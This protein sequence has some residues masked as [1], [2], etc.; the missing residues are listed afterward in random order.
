M[1]KFPNGLLRS[2]V[3]TTS[4]HKTLYAPEVKRAVNSPFAATPSSSPDVTNL[5]VGWA[6]VG[7]PKLVSEPQVPA[8]APS[9]SIEALDP[10]FW[11]VIETASHKHTTT[12]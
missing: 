10:L 7:T 1:A 8:G 4:M 5:A 12:K 9:I 2:I 11:T 3:C 6:T